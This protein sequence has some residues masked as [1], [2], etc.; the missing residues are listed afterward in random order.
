MVLWHLNVNAIM[1]YL[2]NIWLWTTSLKYIMCKD[3]YLCY[4]LNMNLKRLFSYVPGINWHKG[5]R[6]QICP[7]QPLHIFVKCACLYCFIV[8]NGLS[9]IFWINFH[10]IS[11][12]IISYHIISYPYHIISYHIISYHIIS[13]HINNSVCVKY[14]TGLTFLNVQSFFHCRRQSCGY[15]NCEFAS[16]F[17][18]SQIDNRRHRLHT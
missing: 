14:K 17:P 18:S 7:F 12:H 2:R 13:Y 16:E 15:V 5:Q 8:F 10:I 11:Y 1:L 6:F 9:T 4:S 3:V